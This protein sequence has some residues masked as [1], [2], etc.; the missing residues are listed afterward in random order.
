MEELG[1]QV[2]PA[3]SGA[4]ALRCLEQGVFD[5]VITDYRMEPMDG[6]E[7]IKALRERGTKTP[8][9]LLSG[10]VD[11]IGMRPETTGADVVVQKSAN[12]VQTLVRHARRLL[13]APKKP[14]GSDGNV[15]A[16]GASSIS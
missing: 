8:I 2:V 4:E 14:A 5:L 1:Y 3:H 10:F 7:L 12:E 16:R 11:K 9:I 15:R 13:T 6:L